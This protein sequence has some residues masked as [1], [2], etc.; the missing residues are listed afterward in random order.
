MA[1][2]TEIKV[3]FV[4]FLGLGLI[5]ILTIMVG[6]GELNLNKKTYCIDVLF[7][8]VG[9]LR[10]NDTVELSGMEIGRVQSLQIE[11]SKIRVRL[12]LNKDVKIKSDCEIVIIEKSLLGGRVV[13]ISMGESGETV[14]PG[15]TLKGKRVP[16]TTELIAKASKIGEKLETTL[17][18]VE[19]AAPVLTST[20][21]TMDRI[22]KRIEEGKGTLGKLVVEEDLYED[23]SETL[24]SARAAADE[25]AKFTERVEQLKTYIGVDSAYND[26]TGQAL[27]KV[28]LRIEP[29]PNKLYLI[30][31][32][33]LTGTGTEWD[34]KDE[35]DL[36]LDLQLGRRFLDNK[37]TG[38]I[39]LFETRVGAGVDYAFNDKLSLSIEGRDVWTEEKDE[40]IDPFLMRSRLQYRIWRGLFIHVGADNILDEPAV[41]FGLRL[42]YSDEDIKYMLS[43]LNIS[44]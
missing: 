33:A 15:T 20:L 6:Q 41:N 23:V 8:S 18:E 7:D 1:A 17:T 16:G 24:K 11:R 14:L 32:A 25:V 35:A 44:Q 22:T 3:G 12:R 5:V 26:D 29:K 9:G 37:L 43:I 34:E 30:G 21:E 27:S 42:E 4:F 13:S 28:Y 38:R 36:E 40:G 31:A 39:G 10:K 2:S 19:S